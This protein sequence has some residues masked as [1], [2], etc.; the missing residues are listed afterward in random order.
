[1]TVPN[2]VHP[3][4][5]ATA[6]GTF[7]A[8]ALGINEPLGNYQ[9]ALFL[10]ARSHQFFGGVMLDP[11]RVGYAAGLVSGEVIFPLTRL[12]GALLTVRLEIE[13]L[14][15]NGIPDKLLRTLEEHCRQLKVTT[16]AFGQRQPL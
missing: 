7:P 5:P 15:P 14:V 12:E 13:A 6:P 16:R 10:G 1:M 4:Q 9:S 2:P 8:C 11:T 3:T